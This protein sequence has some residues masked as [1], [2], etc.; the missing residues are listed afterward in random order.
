MRPSPPDDQ[1]LFDGER[2]KAS[3]SLQHLYEACA[4]EFRCRRRRDVQAVEDY[5][6]GRYPAALGR[7]KIGDRLQRRRLPGAV[8]AQQS[9][10]LAFAQRQTEAAQRDDRVVV[11]RLDVVDHEEGPTLSTTR[12]GGC[13]H[14]FALV[15]GEGVGHHVAPTDARFSC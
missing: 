15:G 9:E 4:H 3:P 13:G 1:I 12:R 5:P 8:G 6:A 10:N 14:Y 7:Q 2:S 11:T